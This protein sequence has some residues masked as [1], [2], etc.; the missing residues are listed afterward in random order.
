MKIKP[1]LINSAVCLVM[2]SGSAC[3]SNQKAHAKHKRTFFD[4]VAEQMDLS[5]NQVRRH[6]KIE[7]G[8]FTPKSTFSGDT[9]F[10]PHSGFPLVIIRN[11]DG[12]VCSYKLLL[13]Y[14]RGAKENT[15]CKLVET[16][17]D[18]DYS[19]D[20]SQLSFKVFNS[21][22]FFTREVDYIRD[23]GKKHASP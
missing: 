3:H 7:N 4:S 21:K 13:V 23:P 20:Y 17:C 11:N 18:E 1:F 14:N 19:S 10:Y 2:L 8:Y 12:L 9:I 15:A 5:F 6:A 16:D 22:Q